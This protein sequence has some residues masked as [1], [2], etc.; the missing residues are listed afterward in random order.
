MEF[1]SSF[2]ESWQVCTKMYVS[3]QTEVR[4]QPVGNRVSSHTKGRWPRGISLE[5]VPQA[6]AVSVED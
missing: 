6:S 4:L 1:H 5:V 3:F 2:G